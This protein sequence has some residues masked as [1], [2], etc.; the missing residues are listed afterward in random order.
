MKITL[1][2]AD[3]SVDVHGITQKVENDPAF[4]YYAAVEWH[5]LYKDYVPRQTG[6]LAGTVH[7]EP[8]EI[9]HTQPYA[10]YQYEGH[11]DH[12]RAENADK[13]S[14]HWDEAAAPTQLPK[15]ATSLQRYIDQGKLKLD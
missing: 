14:R 5:K 4:W 1:S 13:A 8:K 6:V 12:S 3:V 15:L 9:E 2:V 10:H 11:F 7:F